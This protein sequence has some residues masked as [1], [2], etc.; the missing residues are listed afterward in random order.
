MFE[1]TLSSVRLEN[2]T[3]DEDQVNRTL[4]QRL[5]RRETYDKFKLFP[6]EISSAKLATTAR[7]TT[8]K[9]NNDYRA[10]SFINLTEWRSYKDAISSR[11]VQHPQPSD[12]K[13]LINEANA[14]LPKPTAT[15]LQNSESL[16]LHLANILRL[17]PSSNVLT[18]SEPED[19][20]PLTDSEIIAYST[21][22]GL[23]IFI[24]VDGSLMNDGTATVSVN[25]IAPD[26]QPHD[27][28][29]EW[30]HRLAKILL[31]RS[32]RLPQQWGTGKT[33]INMAEAMGFI[34]GEYT[35]P[36]DLP[37]IYITDSNNARTLQRN[38]KNRDQFT[39]RQLTRKIKQGIDQS[40]ANHLEFL[41]S[42][43]P[44]ENELSDHTKQLYAKGEEV[45]KFWASNK[46]LPTS[47]STQSNPDPTPSI[48]D[49]I[50]YSSYQYWDNDSTSTSSDGDL[51][52]PAVPRPAEKNPLSIWPRHARPI[53]AHYCAKGVLSP[54]ENRFL[55]ANSW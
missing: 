3:L 8:E 23:P 27:L 54:I 44:P 11:F 19:N 39:H 21:Q 52:D 30:Q 24:S 26:I 34:I 41:T 16:S 25:L 37:V 4:L 22:H 18:P 42:K 33:C 31:S 17:R 1:E 20:Y 9:F 5:S 47:A 36:P 12:Y 38:I 6:G 15:M 49:D 7:R 55:C 50:S 43:W 40:I 45:C 32:W 10:C 28:D 2:S 51:L 14:F 46:L 35:I 29:M 13:V 53:R 48:L